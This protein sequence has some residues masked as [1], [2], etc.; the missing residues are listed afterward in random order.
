MYHL[1]IKLIIIY[2]FEER[3]NE[4]KNGSV[5]TYHFNQLVYPLHEIFLVIIVD[6]YNFLK[7]RGGKK[8][9]FTPS[10]ENIGNYG[11]PLKTVGTPYCGKWEEVL[12][13]KRKS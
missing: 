7:G 8:M 13:Y 3:V 6:L 5:H 11:Q 1:E 10:C 2:T 12:K 4:E 9:F